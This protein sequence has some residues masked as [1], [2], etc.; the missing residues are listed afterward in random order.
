MYFRYCYWGGDCIL[1]TKQVVDSGPGSP[2]DLVLSSWEIANLWVYSEDLCNYE[3]YSSCLLCIFAVLECVEIVQEDVRVVR[4][5]Y[6][7]EKWVF[8][9]GQIAEE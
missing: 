8:P 6:L 4:S 9:E 3:S 2:S 7:G 5:G 1:C